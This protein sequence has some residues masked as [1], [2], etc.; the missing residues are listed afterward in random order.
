MQIKFQ[1]AV[2]AS[3]SR[4]MGRQIAGKLARQGVRSIAIHYRAGKSEA[5]VTF[6]L[7]G[8]PDALGIHVP[9]DV[10]GTIAAEKRAD[11]AAQKLGGY[12]FFGD[13]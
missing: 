11:Q 3:G 10:A 2:I 4:G 1:T 9:G 6:S 8:E 7:I 5:E 13:L 12:G